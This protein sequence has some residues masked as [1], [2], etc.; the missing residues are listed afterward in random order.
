[1]RNRGVDPSSRSIRVD[2]GGDT[3]RWLGERGIPVQVVD[4][5]VSAGR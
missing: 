1:M 3:E 2:V 4:L 5:T